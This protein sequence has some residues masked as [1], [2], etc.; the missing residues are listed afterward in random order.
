MFIRSLA[1]FHIFFYPFTFF[2]LSLLNGLRFNEDVGHC[3]S[4]LFWT[5]RLLFGLLSYSPSAH[6]SISSTEIGFNLWVQKECTTRGA[7][8]GSTLSFLSCRTKGR[9]VSAPRRSSQTGAPRHRSQ[10]RTG[11]KW[12]TVCQGWSSERVITGPC[13]VGQKSSGTRRLAWR[14]SE[15]RVKQS[16][17]VLVQLCLGTAYPTTAH[18]DQARGHMR[19]TCGLQL[20]V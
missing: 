14:W 16:V 5:C 13:V 3:G 18:T 12:Y 10:H 20:N 1:C 9:R 4:A 17:S 11:G 7:L 8:G 15:R 2:C 6:E 19:W